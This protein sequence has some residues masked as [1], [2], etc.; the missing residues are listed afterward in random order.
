MKNVP[1]ITKMMTLGTCHISPRTAEMLNQE[2]TENKWGLPVYDKSGYGWFIYLDALSVK[3]LH[4]YTFRFAH[5]DLVACADFA[6]QNNC[7]VLC[8]DQDVN[9]V[10]ELKNYDWTEG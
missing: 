4:D 1:I 8:L 2:P 3:I 7:G 6:L 5:P 9:P 10:P